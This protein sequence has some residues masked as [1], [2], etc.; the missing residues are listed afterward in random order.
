MGLQLEKG[1]T[2]K[3]VPVIVL[4]ALREPVEQ[5][6]DGCVMEDLIYVAC[7]PKDTFFAWASAW[8][9]LFTMVW[10]FITLVG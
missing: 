1:N 4:K 2:W 5:Q 8:H 6:N 7:Q 3:C 10:S 9:V